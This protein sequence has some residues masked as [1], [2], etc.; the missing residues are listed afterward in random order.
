MDQPLTLLAEIHDVD[1]ML[2]PTALTWVCIMA[3]GASCLSG[4]SSADAFGLSY[5]VGAGMLTSGVYTIKVTAAKGKRTAQA[6]TTVT[7]VKPDGSP[8]VGRIEVACLGVR[9]SL[10][11]APID[12]AVPL[13]ML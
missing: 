9:C 4:T 12:P 13:S 3:S 1:N 6:S 8:P 5:S 11:N 2:E 10:P 7:V